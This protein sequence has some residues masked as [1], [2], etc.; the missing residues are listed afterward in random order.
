MDAHGILYHHSLAGL[1]TDEMIKIVSKDPL[2]KERV[3]EVDI[4]WGQNT[5]RP[6]RVKG[7]FNMIS[8]ETYDILVFSLLRDLFGLG[9][10]SVLVT[11]YRP[12][13]IG[14]GSDIKK[15]PYLKPVAMIKKLEDREMVEKDYWPPT[16]ENI[17]FR[18]RLGIIV[19]F[20]KIVGTPFYLANVRVQKGIPYLWRVTE[21]GVKHAMT[22][23]RSQF[24][25]LFG[26]KEQDLFRY[27]NKTEL[28]PDEM[29]FDS[30]L[31]ELA[32][33]M[34]APGEAKK[35]KALL[36]D[37]AVKYLRNVDFDMDI[38]REIVHLRENPV[39]GR[40]SGRGR[41]KLSKPASQIISVIEENY[42]T[43][44]GPIPIHMFHFH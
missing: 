9:Y 2:E 29:P 4:K 27:Y 5:L 7:Q 10:P 28:S 18:Y 21:I 38:L 20:C 31:I 19:I 3:C 12:V 22:I 6:Y 14:D 40:I 8:I 23:N 11:D 15:R 44:C 37:L 13:F 42:S 36:F 41:L 16:D 26:F 17:M 34:E 24:A 30:Y 39:R 1:L 33:R 25:D 32:V 43:L 35:P